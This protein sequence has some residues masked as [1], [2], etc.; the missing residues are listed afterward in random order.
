MNLAAS[1]YDDEFPQRDRGLRKV[2]IAC[3][4]IH[5]SEIMGDEDA[6]RE[7]SENKTLLKA[8]HGHQCQMVEVDGMMTPWRARRRSEN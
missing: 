4:Q 3:L 2:I 1:I 5:L 8:L 6:W 7:Y